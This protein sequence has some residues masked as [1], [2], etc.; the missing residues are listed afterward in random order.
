[1]ENLSSIFATKEKPN[2]PLH[3]YSLLSTYNHIKNSISE[4]IF[5]V[6]Y[7][8]FNLIIE[9]QSEASTVCSHLLIPPLL[10]ELEKKNQDNI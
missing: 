1:M 3:I 6:F 10:H 2:C 9:D 7:S 5:G 4:H 8:D